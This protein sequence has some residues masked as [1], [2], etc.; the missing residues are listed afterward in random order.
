MELFYF[1]GEGV[2]VI[3]QNLMPNPNLNPEKWNFSISRGVVVV[4]E[5]NLMPNPN[6]NPDPDVKV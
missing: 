5:Q 2:V 3:E 1:W 6:P 4:I